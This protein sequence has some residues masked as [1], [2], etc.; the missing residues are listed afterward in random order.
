MSKK[1]LE[2]N[3]E[4]RSKM[5]EIKSVADKGVSMLCS[6]GSTKKMPFTLG[7]LH[8][9]PAQVS[10][11]PL[12]TNQEVNIKVII[13]PS[14]KKPME[15]SSPIMFSGMSYGAVSKNVRLVL[16]TVASKLNLGLNSGEDF[17][18]PEELDIASKNLLVQYSVNR[19]GVTEDVLKMAAGVEIRFGQGAYPGWESLLPA[20]K[21]PL[22][23]ATKMGLK[24]GE[25]M[26]TD[27]HHPDITSESELEEK[28][29]WLKEL[30]DGVP[31]GAKIG[32]GNIEDDVEILAKSGV[33]F[34]ALDGF[35]AGTGATEFYVRENVGIPI[36]AA[37]PR[38]D[39]HLK[40]IGLRNKVSLIAGGG[41]R[42]SADFAKCLALGADAVYF[43]TSALIA[44]NCEQYRI[45]H[46][47]H[48]P[49]GVTTNDPVLVQKLNVDEGVRRLTNFINVSNLEVANLLRIVGK[50]DVKKLGLEDLIALE[51][52]L[53]E[54]TGVK[55]LNGK[56]V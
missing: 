21:V 6:M 41:L 33:D 24:E 45:C 36:V 31:V 1:T 46:T 14:A 10:K 56:N 19:F 53:S 34:I 49:T 7:D 23:I 16:A 22:E 17:V 37:L 3:E 54:V 2:E 47:G 35:G 12:N 39:R 42:T 18:L 50:N 44:I 15:L 30:T 52:G 55:W 32:C 28:V 4:L 20:E 26:H 51:K 27:S 11:I 13:G 43:G 40:K 38:A 9:V 25:P 5:A 48:C 29:R 8:F